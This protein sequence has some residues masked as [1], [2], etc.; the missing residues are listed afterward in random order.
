MTSVIKAALELEPIE[1]YKFPVVGSVY[2]KSSK[3]IIG[4]LFGIYFATNDKNE[5]IIENC[6]NREEF[7][8]KLHKYI[9]DEQKKYSEKANELQGSAS[10]LE[11]V[12]AILLR[13]GPKETSKFYENQKEWLK[14]H[15]QDKSSEEQN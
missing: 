4:E 1:V 15:Y 5:F 3:G 8:N 6:Y 11:K 14:K 2:L 13:Q 7:E 10:R 9:L 12:A